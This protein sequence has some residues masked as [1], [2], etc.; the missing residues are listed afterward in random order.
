MK[1]RN[2]EDRSATERG[3]DN[4]LKG[5]A[6]KVKGSI[7]DAVGGAIDDRSMQA[8][9]KWEKVKGS[10]REKFGEVQEDIGRR[11]DDRDDRRDDDRDDRSRL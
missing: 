7:K 3:V 8:E 2:P 11:T 1:S 6:D 5:K 9:G 10:A 4:Q